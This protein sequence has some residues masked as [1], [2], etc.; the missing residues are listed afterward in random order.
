MTALKKY[1]KTFG[2]YYNVL[3]FANRNEKSGLVLYRSTDAA[4]KEYPANGKRNFK[5]RVEKICW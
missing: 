5:K 1:S 4:E 2:R 3:T